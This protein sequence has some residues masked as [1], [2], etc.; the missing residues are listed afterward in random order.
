MS[1][2]LIAYGRLRPY[3]YHLT[4]RS[5][6]SRIR[7]RRS[8]ESA[9]SLARQANEFAIIESR[10][11]AHLPIVVD[12]ESILLRDQSPLHEKNMRLEDGWTFERFI[13]HLNE[14]VFFW[15]GSDTGPNDY[16]W[17]HYGRYETEKPVIV[18]TTFASLVSTNSELVP[19]FAKVNSGSPRWSGGN[20]PARG[21]RT[22]VA[23]NDAAFTAGEVV[24]VTFQGCVELPGDAEVADAPDGPW[25]AL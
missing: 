1:F 7:Q 21:S 24:E 12:G 16:G 18:R 22:F 17:R 20:A 11:A 15:P 4:A 10:R 6:L 25:S 3:L 8:L 5:N 14:R 9:A 19:L 13:A 2:D 23:A